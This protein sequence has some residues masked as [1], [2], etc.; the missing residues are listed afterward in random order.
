MTPSLLEPDFTRRLPTPL[1]L[2]ATAL[3]GET[4][5]SGEHTTADELAGCIEAFFGLIG[6]VWVAEYLAA[7]AP[8]PAANA[9]LHGR[10]VGAYKD[11][12][13]GAWLGTART[14]R[15]VFVER[16]LVPV[17]RGLLDLDFGTYGDDEHPVAKLSAY[18]NSFAHGS[19]HAVVADIVHHRELLAGLV[20]RLPFLVEQPVLVDDGDTVLALRAE[21]ESATRPETALVPHHPTLVGDDGRVV[22]LYPL[23]LAKDASGASA[24]TFTTLEKSKKRDAPSPRDVVHHAQFAIWAERY[25]RELDGDVEAAATCLGAPLDACPAMTE[26]RAAMARL[27]ATGGRLLLVESP[28]AAPRANVL[29]ACTDDGWLR[30]RAVPGE[31]LGSGLVFV[32][33]IARHAERKLGLVRN[34]IGL[35][36]SAAWRNTLDDVASRCEAAGIT[37]LIALDDLH[38]GDAPSRP[39]EPSLQEV[40]RRLA[41]G[42]WRAIAGTTRSWSM[43]P[44]P[45]DV[46]VE[47]DWSAGCDAA[48]LSRFLEERGRTSLHRAVLERLLADDAPSDLF[49]LCDALEASAPGATPHPNVFEPAVERALW[50]LAPVLALGRERRT[51]DDLTEEVRTFVPLDRSRLAAAHEEAR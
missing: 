18:R 1:A 45:W 33:A 43:R 51:R 20:A 10:L 32:K 7:G 41:S 2:A 6:R 40:W 19:F 3:A 13:L 15:Q 5:T 47:L 34:T 37:L 39:G 50:D 22:D 46:R 24:L 31:L 14:L 29:A 21:A 30:W 12:L 4:V 25:Q 44:L 35:S 8:D 42:P 16:G 26:V 23:A 28:P 9:L 11:P 49:G 27:E 36:E 17:A 48:V 38:R